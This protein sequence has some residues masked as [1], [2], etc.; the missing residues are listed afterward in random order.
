MFR[1]LFRKQKNTYTYWKKAKPEYPFRNMWVHT[2]SGKKV[3]LVKLQ[4]E[5]FYQGDFWYDDEFMDYQQ[6]AGSRYLA[7]AMFEV[8]EFLTEFDTK[9]LNIAKIKRLGFVD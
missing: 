3:T 1:R 9:V 6:I 8:D 5:R 4:G 7:D 2:P